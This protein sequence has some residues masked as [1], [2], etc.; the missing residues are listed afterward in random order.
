M[1]NNQFLV[2]IQKKTQLH[3]VYKG[4]EYLYMHVYITL[5]SNSVS[6]QD[7]GSSLGLNRL[8]ARCLSL[9]VTK[10]CYQNTLN[11]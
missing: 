2:Y 4:F 6:A 11:E 9:L 5:I 8:K 10:I 1:K 7:S 3:Y